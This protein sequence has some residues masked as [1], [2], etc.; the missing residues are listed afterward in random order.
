MKNTLLG[1]LIGFTLATITLAL[2]GTAPI[3]LVYS[4]FGFLSCYVPILIVERKDIF[5]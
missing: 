3:F 1:I 4:C 5:E 2:T